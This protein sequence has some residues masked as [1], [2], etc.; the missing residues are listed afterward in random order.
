MGLFDRGLI[1]TGDSFDRGIILTTDRFD[2]GL[3][4]TGIVFTGLILSADR[5]DQ[6]F[7][8]TGGD[9]FDRGFIL[10]G[11][12]VSIS[13]AGGRVGPLSTASRND[14]SVWPEMRLSARR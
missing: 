14:C 8:L 10:T 4:F 9:R 1:L 12:F 5:F 6:G 13:N 7:I 11:G 3:I 2:R